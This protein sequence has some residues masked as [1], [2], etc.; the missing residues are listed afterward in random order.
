VEIACSEE[1]SAV[2]SVADKRAGCF[3]LKSG[4]EIATDEMVFTI[5]PKTVAGILPRS[6]YPPAFF[7]RVEA[8][9]STPGFFTVF[10]ALNEGTPIPTEG[11]G[12][13]TSL[14]PVDDIDALSLPSW[15]APGALAITFS[16]SGKTN[17][18]TAFEPVYWDVV[19]Q[20]SD[21][22]LGDRPDS[23]KRWKQARVDELMARVEKIFPSCAGKTRVVAAC[24]PLTYR[25][26]LHHHEG[27]AYGTKHKVGQMNLLGQSRLRNIYFAG[28]SAVLPG[29]L[30]TIAASLLVA[31]NILGDTAFQEFIQRKHL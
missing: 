5:H 9:E 20:W 31:K 11:E 22:T 23:Y 1:V 15:K 4:R 27:A 6:A 19:S 10:A 7:N 2:E 13:I 21:S 8:L 24:S 26:Y 30:G 28:Q 17:I 3:V 18:L 12:A 25:D 14:Y 29:V 16:R